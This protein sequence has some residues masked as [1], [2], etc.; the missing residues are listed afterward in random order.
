MSEISINGNLYINPTPE[1]LREH[2]ISE[3]KIKDIFDGFKWES[4]ISRRDKLISET[5]WT[6]VLDSP[7]SEEK[8]A[9][10]ANYRQLLRDLPQ[11]YDNPDDVVWPAKPTL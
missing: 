3:S 5:D 9:N 6:Q 10:F 1:L 4:I 2:G 11:A 8:K 7:L